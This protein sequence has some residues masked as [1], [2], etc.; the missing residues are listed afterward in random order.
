MAEKTNT[1]EPFISKSD[2]SFD[3]LGKKQNRSSSALVQ[4]NYTKSDANVVA[5]DTLDLKS[6]PGQAVSWS[7]VLSEPAQIQIPRSQSSIKTRS[8]NNGAQ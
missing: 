7:Q 1:K 5:N 3:Q 8:F 6:R 2:I 4:S